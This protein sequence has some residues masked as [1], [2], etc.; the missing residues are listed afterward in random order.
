MKLTGSAIVVLGVLA[1]GGVA[2]VFIARHAP[3]ILSKINPASRDNLAY[4]G[5]NAIGDAL[6]SDTGPGRYAD[7]SWSLGAWA[8]DVT[9]ANPLEDRSW[10]PLT[11]Y[12]YL[13]DPTSAAP[14]AGA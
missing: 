12:L 13:P 9:H 8:Y 6:V 1:L 11:P 14:Y 3:G 4:Q 2:A 5:V 7:G 10:A